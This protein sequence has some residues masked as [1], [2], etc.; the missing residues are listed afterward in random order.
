M[1]CVKTVTML[2]VGQRE[3]TS[4]DT[5]KES[6]MPKEFVKIAILALITKLRESG[7]KTSLQTRDP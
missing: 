1:V 3:H 6:Y 2:R 7:E 4:A 5:L